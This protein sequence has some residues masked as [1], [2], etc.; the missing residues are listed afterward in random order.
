MRITADSIT[1]VAG[2]AT[3]LDNVTIVAEPSQLLGV[4]G[5]N[6]AGKSTLL[7]VLAG[8]R[9]CA[10]GTVSYDGRSYSSFTAQQLAQRLSY[11]AQRG[12]VAWPLTVERLVA[13][14]RLPHAGDWGGQDA[15]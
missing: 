11:L 3:L 7:R 9:N 8:L 4:V 6:G 2:S 14:G 13:L 5:P 10:R 1:V 12:P 15:E